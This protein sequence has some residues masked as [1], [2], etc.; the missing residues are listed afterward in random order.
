PRWPVACTASSGASNLALTAATNAVTAS[1]ALK[2]AVLALTPALQDFG[3]VTLGSQSADIDF[4]VSNT[5]SSTSGAPTTTLS[6]TTNY[7]LTSNAC[8]G[9][10]VVGASCKIKVRFTP[11]GVS[12]LKSA[13][14]G[15]SA[16]PGGNASA[17]LSGN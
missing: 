8:T 13:T 2:P 3:A 7:T 6:D 12:G 10:L 4:T 5:G 11:M 9:T 17:S 16:S 1:F 15:V 14:L